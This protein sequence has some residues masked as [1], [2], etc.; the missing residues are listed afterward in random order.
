MTRRRLVDWE[1]MAALGSDCDDDAVRHYAGH[2]ATRL[3]S[4]R[5]WACMT[6]DV[7]EALEGVLKTQPKEVGQ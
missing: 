5:D 4:L 7:A 3:A 1:Q 2:L 6:G